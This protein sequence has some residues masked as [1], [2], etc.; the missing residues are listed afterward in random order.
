MESVVI[1]LPEEKIGE[2][3][4]FNVIEQ[5]ETPKRPGNSFSGITRITYWMSKCNCAIIS[6]W[7]NGVNTRKVNNENNKE[8]ER[9]LREAG[10]GVCKCCGCYAEVGKAVSRENSIFT[11]DC[12]KTGEKFFNLVKELSEEFGQ[13]SFLYKKAGEDSNAYL[14][15][16][17]DDFGRGKQE[18]LGPLH[19]ESFTSTCFTS[20]GSKKVAF[21]M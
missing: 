17:N 15:G 18:E 3:E 13:D 10:Y 1:Y 4:E 21:G 5:G 6:G 16:T 8:I 7:R 20:F 14:Y 19:I 12:N 2:L 11:F 9:R